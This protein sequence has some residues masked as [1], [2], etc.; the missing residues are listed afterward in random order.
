M[1]LTTEF[2]IEDKVYFMDNNKVTKA[3]VKNINIKIELIYYW[4]WYR[5]QANII[6]NAFSLKLK[7]D[8]FFKE[9][10]MYASKE[11]LLKSL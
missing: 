7:Q 9:W 5:Q 4:W 1:E 3:E 8:F 6:Y 2:N 11:E 10:E